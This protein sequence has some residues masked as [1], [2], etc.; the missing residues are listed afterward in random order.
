MAK[1]IEIKLFQINIRP[2]YLRKRTGF[3]CFVRLPN[4][5][6]WAGFRKTSESEHTYIIGKRDED[7]PTNFLAVASQIDDLTPLDVL[8][9]GKKLG[10]SLPTEHVSILLGLH[11]LITQLAKI[12]EIKEDK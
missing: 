12:M 4:N 5:E 9:L 8:Q 1:K 2:A 10:F 11:S 3:Y 6:I 7:A